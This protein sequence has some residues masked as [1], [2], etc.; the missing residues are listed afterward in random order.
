MGWRAENLEKL[1]RVR[2]VG[3]EPSADAMGML[4]ADEPFL[5]VPGAARALA[6][7]ALETALLAD[8][9]GAEGAELAPRPHF[10]VEEA[11]A[12]ARAGLGAATTRRLPPR[13][14]ARGHAAPRRLRLTNVAFCPALPSRCH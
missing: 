4:L 5:C 12:A 14:R 7:D 1:A 8:V 11:A 6:R 9:L 10:D 3:H 13:V 2:C